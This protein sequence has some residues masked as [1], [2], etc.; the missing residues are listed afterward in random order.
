MWPEEV[1]VDSENDCLWYSKK[2][3]F[4]HSKDVQVLF[5]LG[6]RDETEGDPDTHG[7]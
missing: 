5:A 6:L 4:K 1:T 7:A 3:A 2:D